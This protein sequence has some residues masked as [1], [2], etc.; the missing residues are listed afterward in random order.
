[1]NET[2]IFKI[3]TKAV[4]GYTHMYYD[5]TVE[6]AKFGKQVV[7]GKGQEKYILRLKPQWN[8][9][10]GHELSEYHKKEREQMA[11]LYQPRTKAAY[12]KIAGYFERVFR[13]DKQ[14]N[15]INIAEGASS[16]LRESLQSEIE[17]FGGTTLLNFLEQQYMYRNGCDPNAWLLLERLVLDGIERINPVI[18]PSWDVQDYE[19]ILGELQYLTIKS[20]RKVKDQYLKEWFIYVKGTKY[21][22]LED[23]EHL[24]MSDKEDST[25]IEIENTSY[26]IFEQLF[27]PVDKIPA[28][29]FGYN[30]D[31]DSGG[32]T[33]STFWDAAEFHMRDLIDR[34][35][36]L[37]M[38]YM[39]HTFLQKVQYYQKCTYHSGTH[40][41]NGGYVGEH[42]CPACK[43]TG[44]KIHQDAADIL[45][46]ELPEEDKPVLKP[47]EIA[48][49]ISMP[50]EI[51]KQQQ[52]QVDDL[53]KKMCEAVFGVDLD[54][55]STGITTAT[56]I[57]SSYNTAY[58]EMNKFANGYVHLYLY[59]VDCIAKIKGLSTDQF[60]VVLTFPNEFD[61]E[62]LPE[63]LA[64]L[65][66]AKESG[67]SYDIIK[68]I[69]RKIAAKQNKGN[70]KQVELSDAL[71]QFKPF[72]HLSQEQLEVK[73]SM[74]D[75]TNRFRVIW[76]FYDM[77]SQDIQDEFPQFAM[78]EKGR[79]EV[80]FNNV[81]DKYI[82]LIKV[83][84]E[85]TS[86]EIREETE[87][88]LNQIDLDGESD[89]NETEEDSD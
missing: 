34:K 54:K 4:L 46:V 43:G 59:L 70:Q 73:L 33:Y 14:A 48:A 36:Q 87:T 11:K 29:R 77:I 23:S 24:E 20:K 3:I 17:N 2:D 85:A 41:C 79:K 30:F 74:L 7:T 75:E 88:I 58:D 13:V 55:D 1:M 72:K 82:D 47:S 56:E 86:D 22:V 19:Y 69:E 81:V 28:I 50:F 12:S 76:E 53:P 25:R 27:T 26:L 39:L 5:H 42:I 57:N 8:E 31:M 10:E 52:A 16:T 44:Q 38:S 51:V 40:E 83:E 9:S 80:V 37:D 62:T 18:V 15:E 35:A 67:A 49:Y 61:L 65:K 68:T 71:L 60:E 32:K 21:I 78:L 84:Q 63:L 64:T 45:L 66:A 6:I 89:G